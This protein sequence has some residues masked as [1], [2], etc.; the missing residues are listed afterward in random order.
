MPASKSACSCK[1]SSLFIN[2]KRDFDQASLPAFSSAESVT[3]LLLIAYL[4]YNSRFFLY[5]AGVVGAGL[6]PSFL[7][8]TIPL[9]SMSVIKFAVTSNWVLS[10]FTFPA[11]VR[12]STRE[13]ESLFHTVL[14]S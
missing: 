7:A 6:N 1:K 12:K 14:P 3:T 13:T 5:S 8:A 2:F 9:S 10:S 11:S 4:L